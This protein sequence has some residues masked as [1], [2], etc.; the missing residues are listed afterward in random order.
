MKKVKN[1]LDVSVESLENKENFIT[2][3]LSVHPDRQ[4]EEL[5]EEFEEGLDDFDAIEMEEFSGIDDAQDAVYQKRKKQQKIVLISVLVF[6]VV[7]A[8]VLSKV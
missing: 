2:P 6:F 7:G 5:E 3:V 1:E 8:I 4:T